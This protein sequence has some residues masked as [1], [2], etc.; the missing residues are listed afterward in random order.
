MKSV[1]D[2]S[3]SLD[4]DCSSDMMRDMTLMPHGS[5]KDKPNLRSISRD[6]IDG[7]TS[8]LP[9][10]AAPPAPSST[11]GHKPPHAKPASSIAN[12]MTYGLG[13]FALLFLLYVLSAGHSSARGRMPAASQYFP[14]YY[15]A[16]NPASSSTPLD[17]ATRAN[18]AA[19]AA[20]ANTGDDELAG[21]MQAKI[22]DRNR[23]EN[24]R[25]EMRLRRSDQAEFTDQYTRCFPDAAQKHLV[26]YPGAVC[27]DG[28]KPAYYLRRG[29]G[30]GL[31]KWI[32]FF[33]GGGWCYSV[34]ACVHRSRTD[35]GS[36]ASYPECLHRNKIRF[37]MHHDAKKNPLM[38]NW[39][40]VLVKYCDGGSYAGDATVVVEAVGAP[41]ALGVQATQG[42]RR[43]LDSEGQ[44]EEAEASAAETISA[45]HFG[46]TSFSASFA[47]PATRTILRFRGRANREGTIQ[48]LL[49]TTTISAATDIVLGG[50]SAGA[51][52]IYLGLD[53]MTAQIR[54]YIARASN[55]SSPRRP[56]IVG[57]ADSG[58]F[59]AH[60]SDNKWKMR[61]SYGAP[62][63]DLV[64]NEAIINGAMDFKVRHL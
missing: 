26:T 32:V 23:R 60:T 40:V 46:N 35:L 37:Y 25:Q 1:K 48:Q 20:A 64:N 61:R 36:S 12:I 43:R 45:G 13:S 49:E 4:D 29:S 8:G 21:M 6:Y 28:T 16:H 63:A 17:D 9:N 10:L 47:A 50:C 38:Y 56:T 51:L 59:M 41:G 11:P 57:F 7:P 24:Y 30:S 27:M 42:R 62:G 15:P 2:S 52:G 14:R 39:N 54:S 22:E 44:H 33:E 53:Q 19:A 18:T 5:Q 31:S 58:F 55:A 3:I 34:P